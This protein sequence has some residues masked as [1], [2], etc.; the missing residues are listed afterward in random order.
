MRGPVAPAHVPSRARDTAA[1]ARLWTAAETL[2]G[3]ALPTPA[4]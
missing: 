3:V 1:A 2:T 4:R